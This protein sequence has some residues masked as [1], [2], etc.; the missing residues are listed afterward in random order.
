R[1]EGLGAGSTRSPSTAGGSGRD[2][3]GR[4]VEHRGRSGRLHARRA[5]LA[6]GARRRL[7]PEH[8]AAISPSLFGAARLAASNPGILFL[9]GTWNRVAE[10]SADR[11]DDPAPVRRGDRVWHKTQGRVVDPSVG[12]GGLRGYG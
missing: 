7:L 2:S 12:V 5:L 6:R 1:N 9:D 11:G 3:A 4:R 10:G 8:P